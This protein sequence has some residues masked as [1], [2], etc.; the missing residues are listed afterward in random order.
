MKRNSSAFYSPVYW[1][2]CWLKYSS[3]KGISNQVFG[4]GMRS[5]VRVLYLPR[6]SRFL[7][8]MEPVAEDGIS[9][10]GSV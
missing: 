6:E 4:E 5:G 7:S 2:G 3:G 9:L 1:I 8:D 10:W